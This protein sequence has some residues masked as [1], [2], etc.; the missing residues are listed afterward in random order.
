[1]SGTREA[2][3][4]DT[5]VFLAWIKGESRSPEEVSGIR[6]CIDEA[7]AGHVLIITS[8]ITRVEVLDCRFDTPEQSSAF[9]SFLQRPEVHCL[10]VD[11]R[12]ALL[13]HEIRDYYQ[14]RALEN[15]NRTLRTPD[16]IHLAT[17]VHFEAR[18]MHT[19]DDGKRGGKS[20]G[21]LGL[22][23]SVAGRNLTVCKPRAAQL[24]MDV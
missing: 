1:M 24:R 22:S 5:C 23:G 9:A 2:A 16:A 4:W 20:L 18:E 14:Q 19:F 10:P 8:D 21:L 7:K 15:D 17:A 3:Y 6:Q 13:A 12:V 11:N